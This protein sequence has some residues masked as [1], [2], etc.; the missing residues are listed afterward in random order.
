MRNGYK[1]KKRIWWKTLPDHPNFVGLKWRRDRGY[2]KTGLCYEINF[3]LKS[4]RG[5]ILRGK[6]KTINSDEFHREIE[7]NEKQGKAYG[8]S[9]QE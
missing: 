1:K 2:K 7:E 6:K 4:G 8:F 5:E 9:E 3:L